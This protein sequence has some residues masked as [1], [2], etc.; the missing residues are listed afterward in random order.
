M[1]TRTEREAILTEYGEWVE[2]KTLEGL[3]L[4]VEAYLE[5]IEHQEN[6]EMV[7]VLSALAFEKDSATFHRKAR[8][9]LGID[10]PKEAL[11]E[12]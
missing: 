5:G 6:A 11:D 2:Q 9:V 8:Y 10:E 12:H 7:E 1:T 3:D 4:S